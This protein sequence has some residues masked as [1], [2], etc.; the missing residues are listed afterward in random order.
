[1]SRPALVAPSPT[2][3]L[4]VHRPELGV[5][6]LANE[7]GSEGD[8]WPCELCN[9]VGVREVVYG[10]YGESGEADCEASAGG[11][12]GFG[13]VHG[14]SSRGEGRPARPV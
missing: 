2:R 3:F 12:D 14:Y 4:S 10:E 9:G 1:M 13:Y 11:C 5:L 6:T 8:V 7:D